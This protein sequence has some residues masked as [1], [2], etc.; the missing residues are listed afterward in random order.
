MK[1][2]IALYRLLLTAINYLYNQYQ[3]EEF[4]DIYENWRHIDMSQHEP[5]STMG[6]Q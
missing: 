1:K 3:I 6:C 4:A 5:W 2:A